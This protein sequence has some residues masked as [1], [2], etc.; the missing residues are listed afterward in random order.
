MTRRSCVLFAACA[1]LLTALAGTAD[2]WG[3]GL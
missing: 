2:L 3:V 1:V